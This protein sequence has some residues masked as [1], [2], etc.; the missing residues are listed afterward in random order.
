MQVSLKADPRQAIRFIERYAMATSLDFEYA[1]LRLCRGIMRRVMGI[2]PPA[3][4][5]RGDGGALTHTD[6]KRGESA[7]D[8]DLSALF[9]P[10]PLKGLREEQWPD[11]AGIH[12]QI[13]RTAKRPGKRIRRGGRADYY[14]DERK[15]NALRKVLFARIGKLASGW[16]SG[17]E[18]LKATGAP[19]WVR[20]H[21][22][23]RGKHKLLVSLSRTSMSRTHG[24][25]F[26]A[27]NTGV[28]P[29]L[30]PELD[31]RIAYATGYA[32]NA[33]NRETNAILAKR[34]QEF[35]RA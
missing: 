15:L 23:A 8:S 21:G 26:V 1:A 14:V 31:R 7:I 27:A 28:H 20:R 5:K 30:V 25:T 2:T 24:F 18:A 4:G 17:M 22:N 19:A 33:L 32:A 6:K 10:V 9:I 12:G 35:G 13:F 11:V 16:L 34:G 29:T 3:Y